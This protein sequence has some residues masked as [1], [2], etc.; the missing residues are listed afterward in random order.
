M[1]KRIDP[2]ALASALTDG[3]EI[4]LVDVRERGRFAR[5]HLLLAVNMPL[6]RLEL[7]VRQFVP[8]LATRIVLCDDGEGLAERA[9]RVLAAAGYSD[10]ALL[11]GGVE[12]W[13]AAGLE[14]FR[15]HYASS[16]AFGL[17]VGQAYATPQI[18]AQALKARVDAGEKVVILDTRTAPEFRAQSIP[19]AINTPIPELVYRIRDLAADPEVQIVVNCGAVTRGVLGCQ[20]LL[21]AAVENPVVVLTNGIRGW[22]LAGYAFE[23][24]ATRSAGPASP[25]ARAWAE[26]AAK[27]VARRFTVQS[28]TPTALEDWRADAATR[29]LYLVDVRTREE[30]EGGHI[31]GS[32]WVPG[33]ELVGCTEDYIATRNARICLVDD[34]GAR[35]TI[36]ASWL[37]RMGWPEVAVLE[38]GIAGQPLEQGPTPSV[39]PEL[40]AVDVPSISA[41]QLAERIGQ[42]QALV[43]DFASSVS[44]QLGHVPGAWWTVRSGLPRLFSQLPGAQCYVSTSP[45]ARLALLAAV[46]MKRLTQT[47]VMVLEGGSESWRTAGYELVQGMVRPLGEIDDVFRDFAALPGDDRTTIIASHRRNIDWQNGLIA[48]V[49]RDATFSFPVLTS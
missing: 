45:D 44:Y 28:I 25:E 43:V 8:C 22:D 27:A 16:Y 5:A 41:G 46:D 36:T 1:A 19:G 39:I 30:Y 34:N 18:S 17:Y 47:P 42:N 48:K 10:V 13:A 32:M 9:D 7:V 31:A 21:E 40:E 37:S 20:S 11:E 6:S 38:G 35:A 3:G 24:G 15:N 49:D 12:S 23:H 4:A 26:R 2:G 33:G 29:T 14:L